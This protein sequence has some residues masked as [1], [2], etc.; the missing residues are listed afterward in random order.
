MLTSKLPNVGVTIF[1]RMTQLAEHSGAINLSQGFPGFDGPRALREAVGRHVM[2]GRNQYAPMAGLPALREQVAIKVAGLYQRTLD[3]DTEITIT[4]GATEAI[5]CAVQ[6]VVGA[7]DEVVVLDPCYDSYEPSVLLAGGR[8][9]HVPLTL[10]DFAIDWQRLGEAITE[11][12]R[13]I[14]INSPHNPSGAVI[15][16]ADLDQLAALIRERDIYLLADEVYEHLVFD[17]HR[18]ASV[19]SHEELYQRAFVVSSFGKTYH[20]TGWKTGYVVAPPALSAELRKVHQYVN[21]CGVMPIQCALA[22][23]MAAHP[24]HVHELPAFYQAKRDH[25]CDLLAGSRFT[26]SR[27]P[28]TYFQLADYSALRDDLDDV[29]MAEWLAREKGVAAIPVSVFYQRP[30]A[31]SR[32]LR[33]CFAKQEDLLGEAAQRLCEI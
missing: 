17:G 26:F 19:L 2:A 11:R 4:P 29:A 21:F 14:I 15:P 13:L 25:F 22:E 28:G 3:A 30:P 12:T 10:P 32:L 16:A 24:E 8:C 20:V 5:F 33:F 6:T 23:F 9:V 27:T 18:H 1:T 31:T 7:G